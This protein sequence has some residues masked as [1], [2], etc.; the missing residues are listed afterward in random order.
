[1]RPE[2]RELT[3]AEYPARLRDLPK[4]PERLWVVGAL[5]RGPSVA[6]VGTRHPSKDGLAFARRIA[7]ELAEA[8]VAIFSGGAEGIDRAAH[9]GALDA[10]GVTV[11]VAPSSFDEPYPEEHGP[12]YERIVESGGA[13]VTSL[14]PGT[15]AH[16]SRFFPRN[17]QLVALTQALLV[18][19]TRIIGGSRNAVASARRLGRP[20]LVMPGLPWT[21]ETTGCLLE[22]RRGA[23]LLTS[24][25]DA[26]ALLGLHRP[27]RGPGSGPGPE[28]ATDALDASGPARAR[29]ISLLA[30]GPRYP[31]DLCREGGVPAAELQA[32]LLTLTLEGIV[33]SGPSGHV[34]LVTV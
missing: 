32:L 24:A 10:G 22:L 31:D 17:S 29:V 13:F 12:L 8:G 16:T 1:M 34:L 27:R 14:P 11:V 30:R 33:V 19:E 26:L 9:E 15:K 25:K 3:P 4:P 23:G 2:L 18:V 5:P 21:K 28:G 6:I 7:K 20:V